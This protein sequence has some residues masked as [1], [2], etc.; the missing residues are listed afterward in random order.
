MWSTYS[1]FGV[2]DC[3]ANQRR[4]NVV[5][6]EMPWHQIDMR[7]HVIHPKRNTENVQ[8]IKLIC[9][10]M[11][12]LTWTKFYAFFRLM[13]IY[14]V[15]NGSMHIMCIMAIRMYACIL[16]DTEFSLCHAHQ[17]IKTLKQYKMARTHFWNLISFYAHSR[18]FFNVL[19]RFWTQNIQFVCLMCMMHTLHTSTTREIEGTKMSPALL[20]P[21]YKKKS[22]HW[23]RVR[24]S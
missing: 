9:V 12:Y 19:F 7:Q 4:E 13:F 6:C 16:F 22:L 21:I 11:W 5:S 8:S 1:I 15:F 18:F 2:F 20:K 10:R 14:H 24:H 3:S 23:I 17:N